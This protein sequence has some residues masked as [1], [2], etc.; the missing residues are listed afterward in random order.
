MV[1][2]SRVR[3]LWY[4]FLVI[5]LFLLCVFSTPLPHGR[6]D[7]PGGVSISLFGGRLKSSVGSS[8]AVLGGEQVSSSGSSAAL[9]DARLV[10]VWLALFCITL[11]LPY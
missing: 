10:C 1:D 5:D 6:R 9:S 8:T 3:A 2:K 11:I 4:H 7:I